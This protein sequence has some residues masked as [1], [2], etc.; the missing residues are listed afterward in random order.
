[1]SH[2]TSKPISISSPTSQIPSSNSE[3]SMPDSSTA[4]VVDGGINMGNQKTSPSPRHNRHSI[5]L[6]NVIEQLLHGTCIDNPP[7]E[8]ETRFRKPC[9]EIRKQYLGR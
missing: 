5:S 2:E 9:I 4:W 1:M 6:S 7:A 8:S 3:S